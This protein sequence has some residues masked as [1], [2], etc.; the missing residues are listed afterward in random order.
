MAMMASKDP[1]IRA[2][3]TGIKNC[4]FCLRFIVLGC[5]PYCATFK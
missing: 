3:V 4:N 2:P 5:I 1:Q